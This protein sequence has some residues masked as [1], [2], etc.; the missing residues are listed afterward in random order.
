[1]LI[2]LGGLNRFMADDL[3]EGGTTVR[4][5]LDSDEIRRL[6]AFAERIGVKGLSTA[7][8]AAAFQTITADESAHQEELVRKKVA[9]DA[10][11]RQLGG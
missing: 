5:R 9:A 6:Q 3:S 4:T 1:M 10:L 2:R 7:L 11:K 8:R